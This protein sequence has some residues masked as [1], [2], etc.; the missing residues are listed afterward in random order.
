MNSSV[1]T[2]MSLALAL[3]TGCDSADPATV[4][5]CKPAAAVEELQRIFLHGEGAMPGSVVAVKLDA[6]S[7]SP[8][9][10]YASAS[11]WP[12]VRVCDGQ[13]ELLIYE[14]NAAHRLQSLLLCATSDGQSAMFASE[15]CEAVVSFNNASASGATSAGLDFCATLVPETTSGTMGSVLWYAFQLRNSERGPLQR[16]SDLGGGMSHGVGGEANLSGWAVYAPLF[17]NPPGNR[18]AD[19]VQFGF[20]PEVPACTLRLTPVVAASNETEAKR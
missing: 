8:L 15:P 12:V 3:M 16:W 13:Q 10:D 1:V 18:A 20:T 4:L 7:S 14:G 11:H 17:V 19:T 9:R 2:A 5:P 6:G